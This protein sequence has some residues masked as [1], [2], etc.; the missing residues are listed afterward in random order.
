MSEQSSERGMVKELLTKIASEPIIPS[1]DVR[2]RGNI[3]KNGRKPVKVTLS[4][5]AE[6]LKNRRNLKGH[7]VYIVA[8]LTTDKGKKR[9]KLDTQICPRNT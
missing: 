7:D 1:V 6:V 2:R 3:N 9:K 8:Y 5:H 4:S